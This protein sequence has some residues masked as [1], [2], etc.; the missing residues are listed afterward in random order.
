[1]DMDYHGKAG[2]PPRRRFGDDVNLEFYEP[3]PEEKKKI[4]YVRSA[5]RNDPE[6]QIQRLDKTGDLLS[7]NRVSRMIDNDAAVARNFRRLASQVFDIFNPEDG[8]VTLDQ[9]AEQLLGDIKT[10]FSKLFPNVELNS[11][12]NP[13][14]TG[15]FDSQREQAEVSRSKISLGEKRP[16]SI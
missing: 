16:R 10:A 1:M 2:S 9:F 14:E 4:I 5:Y 3:L 6:F 15:P 11:L 13:L 8:S 12:G 7:E